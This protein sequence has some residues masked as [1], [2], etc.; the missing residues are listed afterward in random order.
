M[1]SADLSEITNTEL[2][3]ELGRLTVN[4]DRDPNNP[5]APSPNAMMVDAPEEHLVEPNGSE[6]DNN[7]A[8]INPDVMESDTPL[9]NDCMFQ[10][11]CPF[12][13]NP[14]NHSPRP[15]C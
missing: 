3:S 4:Q 8:I 1:D 14:P 13:S 10:L 7:V 6:N 12:A 9:A 2:S 15:P 5:E 11:S